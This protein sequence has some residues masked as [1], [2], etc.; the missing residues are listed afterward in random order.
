MKMVLF[1]SI[2]SNYRQNIIIFRLWFFCLFTC[3]GALLSPEV[4]MALLQRLRGLVDR[5]KDQ[6]RQRD[7]ELQSKQNEL[8]SVC[9]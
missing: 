4:D 6:L 9:F 1:T 8:D 3:A 5:L 2:V 7:R